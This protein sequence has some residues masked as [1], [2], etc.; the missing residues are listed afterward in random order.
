MLS[1]RAE[2][3]N[4]PS[5]QLEDDD[6]PM[7]GQ[8]GR[9]G[10]RWCLFISTRR[11]SARPQS[12]RCSSFVLSQPWRWLIFTLRWFAAAAARLRRAIRPR[13]AV[14]LEAFSHSPLTPSS[15]A[16][17]RHHRHRHRCRRQTTGNAFTLDFWTLVCDTT[18]SLLRNDFPS[19]DNGNN[20]NSSSSCCCCSC[21]SRCRRS[22]DV[23][24]K[25]VVVAVVAVV[26]VV[27]VVVVI[28]Y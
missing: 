22:C 2:I 25:V 14:R 13:T 4:A 19:S 15:V 21:S 26:V 27:V 12:V 10:G 23:C 20:I 24:C 9:R 7:I 5:R 28:V 18:T 17:H 11:S 8:S 3:T 6:R 16:C 1:G